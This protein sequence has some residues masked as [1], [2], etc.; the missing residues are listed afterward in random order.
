MKI[1]FT[2]LDR[3][4]NKLATI[5]EGKIWKF[6]IDLEVQDE[7][8]R[9]NTEDQLEEAGIDSLGRSLGEYSPF[10]IIR[11]RSKG[12]RFDHIT[13]KDTGKFYDSWR[14]VV[15][16]DGFTLDADDQKEDTALFEVYGND[17]L[18]LT[19]ENKVY[20]QGM[21]I[22]NYIKYLINEALS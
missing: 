6:A 12:Q 10:T 20:L 2:R 19:D 22:E 4:L 7:I 21:I 1:D 13:L 15:N 3:M 16:T 9:M 17:V 18:G 14:I 5:D 8:I 11:K